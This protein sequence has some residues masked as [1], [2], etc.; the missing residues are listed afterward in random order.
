MDFLLNTTFYWQLKFWS[1]TYH[2]LEDSQESTEA[3]SSKSS[4]GA[5]HKLHGQKD[6][7]TWLEKCQLMS[8]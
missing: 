4:K 2:K 8:T 6:I 7:H 3:Q 1:G 5:I